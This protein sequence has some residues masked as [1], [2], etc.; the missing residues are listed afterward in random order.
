MKQQNRVK[1]NF[2]Q[3]EDIKNWFFTYVDNFKS[4]DDALTE[5]TLLKE[6]HT[7]R[8]CNEILTL[9]NALELR[10]DELYLAEITALLHDIGRFEQYARYK[11]FVD[12]KS[13]N[14]AALGTEI[15]ERNK[16]LSAIDASTQRLILRIIRYHNLAYLPEDETAECLFFARLLRDADK[17]DIWR[18]VTRYYQRGNRLRNEALELDLPDTEEISESVYTDLMND[19]IVNIR[20]INSLNDFKLLQAGWVFDLNFKQTFYAVKT[21]RYLDKI[22]EALPNTEKIN[23]VFDNIRR[24]MALKFTSHPVEE[25]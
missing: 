24:Y 15:V 6:N 8:V 4:G 16:V 20:H 2:R 17:L 1:I 5:N 7:I 22:R 11:T 21:R 18:V 3:L 25:K 12:A 13:L 9:G 14:H 19:R 10:T 23:A